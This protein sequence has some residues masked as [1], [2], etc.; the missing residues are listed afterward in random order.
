MDEVLEPQEVSRGL[1]VPV[2]LPQGRDKLPQRV[3]DTASV[4]DRGPDLERRFEVSD[5]I[6]TVAEAELGLGER[7]E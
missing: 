5:R 6:R 3:Y 2:G 1:F 4:I 7:S